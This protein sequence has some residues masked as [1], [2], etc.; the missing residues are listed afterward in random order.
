MSS[1]AE[2]LPAQPV[3][4]LE[5]QQVVDILAD[6]RA[7]AADEDDGPGDMASCIAEL[8]AEAARR[9]LSLPSIPEPVPAAVALQ[10][11]RDA[12]DRGDVETAGAAIFH[13][14]AAGLWYASYR[15]RGYASV[16]ARIYLLGRVI[17]CI[18]WG[19]FGEE[20]A[21]NRRARLTAASHLTDAEL[22]A[23]LVQCVDA[24]LTVSIVNMDLPY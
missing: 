5:D 12:M 19:V 24:L 1:H 9:N 18:E 22:A 7:R 11:F 21:R 2:Y 4:T 13:M 16:Q 6:L 14:D 10:R 3:S 8:E 23:Y 20:R 17:F 15:V